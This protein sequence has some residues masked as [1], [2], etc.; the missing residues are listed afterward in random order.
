MSKLN[1]MCLTY[2]R[3]QCLGRCFIAPQL[4][5][6]FEALPLALHNQQGTKVLLTS[7]TVSAS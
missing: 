4:I 3:G 5:W 2:I 6:N 7:N 1:L